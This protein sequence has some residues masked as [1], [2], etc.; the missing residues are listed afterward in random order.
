MSADRIVELIHRFIAINDAVERIVPKRD[1]IYSE[2]AKRLYESKVIHTWRNHCATIQ[3]SIIA[4]Q[5]DQFAINV[6]RVHGSVT[7]HRMFFHTLEQY[8][9]SSGQ[10]YP[11]IRPISVEREQLATEPP[12]PPEN[13]IRYLEHLPVRRLQRQTQ[14]DEPLDI[15]NREVSDEELSSSDNE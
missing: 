3:V 8:V 15:Y 14:I 12:P 2:P 11:I 1:S 13:H 5:S 4:L 9:T 6:N 7:A 10:S